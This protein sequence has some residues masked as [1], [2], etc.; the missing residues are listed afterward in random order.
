MTDDIL[1][2]ECA[3]RIALARRV[4]PG[5]PLA[6]FVEILISRLGAPITARA[7]DT[8]T[9]AQLEEGLKRTRP[10]DAEGPEWD[11]R[12]LEMALRYLRGEREVEPSLP[13]LDRYAEGD[14][15][16]SLRVALASN[17]G[18]RVDGHFGSCVR[19]LVYQVSAEAALLVDIR[20]TAQLDKAPERNAARAELI[21]DCQLLF[22]GSIGGPAAARV[23]RA[24]VHPIK[25]PE[26]A[27]ARDVLDELQGVLRGT[28]PPWLARV[29]GREPVTL[30][31][32]ATV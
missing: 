15:P 13:P 27:E 19:F 20:P 6:R 2:R 3:L 28:P 32:F 14:L 26:G 11:T 25:R 18:E 10:A 23:I 30:N 16:G 4:L 5:I 21:G 1:D 31:R 22:V 8:L 24:G 12:G 29:M 9:I 17:T 7:L